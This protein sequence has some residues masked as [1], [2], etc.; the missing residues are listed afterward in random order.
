MIQVYKILTGKYDS[1]IVPALQ[2][3]NQHTTRGHE[4]KLTTHRTRYNTRKYFFS[5]RIVKIWNSLPSNVISAV[6]V[7]SFEHLLDLHWA[8]QE[9]RFNYEAYL[10][11]S[12]GLNLEM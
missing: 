1:A 12:T 2:L 3:S 6:T 11:G 9:C 10:T 8:T 4:L 5:N 7:A